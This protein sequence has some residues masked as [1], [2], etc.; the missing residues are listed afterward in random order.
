MKEFKSFYKTVTASEGDR[1]RYNTRL[2]VYGCGCLHDCAYC[3]AKSLL[4]F[5]GLWNPGEPAVA[6][7][8]KIERKL[9]KVPPGTVLRMGGMTDCFQPCERQ[10]R[11]AYETIKMLNDRN[12]GYLIVTKSDMVAEYTDILRPDL[13]HIQISITSLDA[14][15]YEKAV[16]PA[17]RIKAVLQLQDEYDAAL[18]ISPLFHDFD[19][20]DRLNGLGINKAV[21]EFL[22][23]NTWVR[24]WLPKD[25]SKYT[26]K[27]GGYM[28]LPLEEKI[29]LLEQIK[30]PSVTV[31]ED[32][33]EHYA[34]WRD[35]INPN[36]EDCC[37]LQYEER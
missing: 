29:R 34:Y 37:N 16:P 27:S 6:D 18:R 15:D 11:A 23:V 12:I 21:I 33:P 25:Y 4:D 22:R 13:A 8:R 24:K 7:L 36:K 10:H 20:F 26:V 2:D 19:D 3:Y 5:R 9:N 14:A 30:I 1:C 28:H 17:R 35:N 32:V 31:C